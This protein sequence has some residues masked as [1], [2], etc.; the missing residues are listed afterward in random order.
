[1]SFWKWVAAGLV[2][3]GA[4]VLF[5]LQPG[6]SLDPDLAGRPGAAVYEKFCL[7]CH[8][9]RGEGVK[10]ARMAERVVDFTS[11]AFTDTSSLA[12]VRQVVADGRGRMKGYAEKLTPAEIDS[13]SRFV[14]GLAP[15]WD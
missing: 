9:G 4:V 1:M 5:V 13:V 12:S 2:A 15:P 8:G 6:E 3:A 11:P 14:L 7:R 10:A